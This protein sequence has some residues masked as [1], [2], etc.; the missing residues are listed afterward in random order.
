MF[1]S[2][3]ASPGVLEYV[4]INAPIPNRLSHVR[5][6]EA[7]RRGEGLNGIPQTVYANVRSII[8]LTEFSNPELKS[9]PKT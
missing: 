4:P 1:D 6:R 9:L 3:E 2:I 8:T 5:I 7:H